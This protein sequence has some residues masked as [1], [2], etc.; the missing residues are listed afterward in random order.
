MDMKQLVT[1]HPQVHQEFVNSNHA[2]SR[3]SKPFA[4]V[5]TDMALEQS[6]NAD[7][8]SRGG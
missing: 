4:Q 3:S 2:I 7:S 5:W 1:K 6:I 8:K